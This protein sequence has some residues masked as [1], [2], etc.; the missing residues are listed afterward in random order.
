MAKSKAAMRRGQSSQE[1]REQTPSEKREAREAEI[2]ERWANGI[3]AD[4]QAQV[5]AEQAQIDA[6]MKAKIPERGWLQEDIG[7]QT[8]ER[9]TLSRMKK[10]MKEAIDYDALNDDNVYDIQYNDGKVI[11]A[12][13]E[14]A[15]GRKVKMT[16]IK[17][18]INSNEETTAFAGKVKIYSQLHEDA[19]EY[20]S[21][22]KKN[23]RSRWREPDKDYGSD[24]RVDFE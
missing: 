6:F 24:W 17:A 18:I 23:G 8:F 13:W 10:E 21:E 22:I 2:R 19:K 12:N 9:E 15:A 14:V 20:L 7:D 3:P 11:R 4:I 16:G 5:D 1:E